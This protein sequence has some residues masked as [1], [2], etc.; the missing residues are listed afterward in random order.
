MGWDA[1]GLP[2]ENY[3]IKI[4]K[5]PKEIAAENIANFRRQIQA[6]GFSYD[7]DREINTSDPTYYRWT[8]WLFLK[9]YEKGLAYR[10][11][12]PVN[13]CP[14]CQTVLANEQVVDGKCER[15]KSDVVQKN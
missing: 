3:A 7:W 6:L 4:G 10:K 5:N 9:L 8:Q 2:T 1:F 14:S 13:W 12:A 11:E 15:C